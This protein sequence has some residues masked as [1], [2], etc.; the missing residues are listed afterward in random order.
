MQNVQNR[1]LQA[2]FNLRGPQDLRH[3]PP[4]RMSTVDLH[5]LARLAFP[6]ALF[7]QEVQVF[8]AMLRA[9]GPWRIGRRRGEVGPKGVMVVADP[10]GLSALGAEAIAMLRSG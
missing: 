2:R 7:H 4:R 10:V 6:F 1:L 3:R 5:R 8:Q 9:L